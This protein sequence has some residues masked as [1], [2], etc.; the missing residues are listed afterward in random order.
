MSY[1][2]SLYFSTAERFHLRD[3][4]FVVSVS[5]Y[6]AVRVKEKLKPLLLA[7]SG[8]QYFD[9]TPSTAVL[10]VSV[11]EYDANWWRRIGA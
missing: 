6:W 7:G 4:E 2:A 8:H 3:T 9:V 5:G 11:G 10:V 1:G